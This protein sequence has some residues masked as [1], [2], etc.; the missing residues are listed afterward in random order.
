[1][2]D[3]FGEGEREAAVA[4][5][6]REVEAEAETETEREAAVETGGEGEREAERARESWE[7]WVERGKGLC[8]TAVPIGLVAVTLLPLI[9]R[10]EETGT[11]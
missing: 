1:L 4:E 11:G 10:E 3:P 5:T 2:I 6:E 8:V 9:G 7:S